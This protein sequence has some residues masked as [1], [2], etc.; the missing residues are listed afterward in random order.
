MQV[1][2]VQFHLQ[3]YTHLHHYAQQENILNFY[4]V[5]PALYANKFSINLLAQKLQTAFT[6]VALSQ[7][8]WRTA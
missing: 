3:N 1:G 7:S 2:T 8:Y 4:T 5:R 6:Q